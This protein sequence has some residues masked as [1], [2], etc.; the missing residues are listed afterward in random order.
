MGTRE[1]IIRI[2]ED[3]YD[4]LMQQMKLDRNFNECE[5]AELGEHGD[6]V[7][8]D[9]I[10]NR[11]YAIW[12]ELES[13]SNQPSYKELLDKWSMCL[14]AADPIIKGNYEEVGGEE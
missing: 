13:Y 6:L 1:I 3:K 8:R 4:R 10:N 12:K 2:P 5:I 11:F 9:A 7:D 14:D